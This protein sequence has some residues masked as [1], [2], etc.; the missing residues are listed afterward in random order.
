MDVYNFGNGDVPAHKHKN[1]GGWIANTV[2]IDD[3]C[4]VGPYAVVFDNATI[5]D[6][7][8]IND[9]ARVYGNTIV[10][11]NVR[12][13]GNAKI[14]DNARIMNN[15]RVC[16]EAKVYGN[17]R[18]YD[19]VYVF[20]DAKIYDYAILKNSTEVY[21]NAIIFGNSVLIEHTKIYNDCIVTRQP[22]VI[23]GKLSEVTNNITISDHHI[24]I[25][26]IV[27]PP[28]MWKNYGI[29]IFTLFN[30]AFNNMKREQAE[31]WL[32]IIIATS[33][34]HGCVDR[35][36]DIEKIKNNKVIQRIMAGETQDRNI[37]M[38]KEKF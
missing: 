12:V 1:G 15:A 17:A 3:N 29:E 4:Y 19:N 23:T 9:Y 33:D 13:Y 26:C 25:G 30:K 27:L 24:T 8:K 36:E 20:D 11:N 16:G 18:L 6:S 28:S 38:W 7:V 35:P 5:K 21:E 34:F 22:L 14:Y 2:N 32:E 10:T 37:N 31:K